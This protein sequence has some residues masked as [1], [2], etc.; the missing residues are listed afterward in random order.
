MFRT[1]ATLALLCASLHAQLAGPSVA[2][3]SGRSAATTAKPANKIL[4]AAIYDAVNSIDKA[5][6][7]YLVSLPNASRK[8][9]KEVAVASA[10]H[11]IL[12]A[13]YPAFQ[14]ALDAQL[15]Q[16]LA[17][18]KDGQNKDD[19]IAIGETV[20][21]QI[22]AIRSADGSNATPPQFTPGSKPGDY[23]LTPPNLAHAQF[24]QWRNVAPFAL[25]RADEFRPGPP[26]ALTSDKYTAV[27]NEVKAVG[28]INSTTRTADQAFIGHFWN[29]AIQNYWNEITQTAALEHNLDIAQSARLFALLNISLADTVIAFYDAKYTYQF[30]RPVTAIQLA[31]TDGNPN[32][33]PNTT[34]LPL[35]TK[36]APDPS[37]PGAHSA[38]SAAGATVLKSFFAND[39]F[40]LV[41][42][43]EVLPGVERTFTKLS[44]AAQEAGLSRIYA[45]QHFR[46]DHD[47]GRE[48][49]SDVAGFVVSN[50][51][52]RR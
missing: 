5:H 39:N 25:P 6:N 29:G 9:S 23:Q 38:I 26:P 51:L 16:D 46:S 10:A 15:Q 19:G 24:T 44:A 33:S 12:V 42:T 31:D 7:S 2:A 22:L 1:L 11:T 35:T 8:A 4:H 21:N 30:W 18:V 36:T 45:G 28:F 43:S 17:G 14:T 13:L 47:A 40:R 37:Y 41:V 32:T 27:F 20:A 48:L 3:D 34:W 50:L 49:G 52:L